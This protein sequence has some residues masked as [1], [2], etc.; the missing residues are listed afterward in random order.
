MLDA[1]DWLV[2]G[3]EVVFGSTDVDGDMDGWVTGRV[4][5]SGCGTEPAEV[6]GST[7]LVGETSPGVCAGLSRVE[8]RWR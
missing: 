2:L 1:V 3:A 5:W 7:A 8:L 6:F 4:P